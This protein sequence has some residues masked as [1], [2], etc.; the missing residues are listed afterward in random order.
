MSPTPDLLSRFS[1]PRLPRPCDDPTSLLLW[2]PHPTCSVTLQILPL[3]PGLPSIPPTLPS[4]PMR[5]GFFLQPPTC[6]HARYLALPSLPR[7]PQSQ[8]SSRNITELFCRFSSPL[9]FPPVSNI[10]L[11]TDSFSLKIKSDNKRSSQTTACFFCLSSDFLTKLFITN[12]AF[13]LLIDRLLVGPTTV[14]Y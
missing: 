12:L 9:P 4:E 14:S 2:V 10:I 6:V 11:Q 7:Y 13:A 5:S 8:T 1:P 3:F